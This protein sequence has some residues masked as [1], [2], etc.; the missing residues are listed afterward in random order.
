MAAPVGVTISC[1]I[2][3]EYTGMPFKISTVAGEGIGIIPCEHEVRPFPRGSWEQNTFLI[4][5]FLIPITVPTISIIES[6][7]PTS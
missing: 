6:I 3:A 4:C 1:L 2:F 5:S 7:A